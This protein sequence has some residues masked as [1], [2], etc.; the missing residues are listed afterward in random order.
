[1]VLAK[2]KIKEFKKSENQ[3]EDFYDYRSLADDIAA[4]GDKEWAAKIFIKAEKNAEN[5]NDYI[6]LADSINAKLGDKKNL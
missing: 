4:A 6:N 2:E 5:S 1:M 3:A